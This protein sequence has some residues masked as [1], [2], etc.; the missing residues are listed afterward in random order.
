MKFYVIG[1]KG[2]GL[3]SLAII[4]KNLGHEVKG[5]DVKKYVFTEDILQK[6]NIEI[7]DIESFIVD[8]FDY[9]IIGNTFLDQFK[10]KFPAEKIMTYQQCLK[11]F[12]EKN[13]SLAVCGTHGKTTTTWMLAKLFNS[14]NNKTSYLVGD[15][16]GKAYK[17]ANYFI[18]EAC[19]YC[20][21][22][23]NYYPKSIILTNVDYDHVD[24]FKTK[25][26]YQE[27]FNK[28]LLHAKDYIF[29]N[30]EIEEK[31]LMNATAKILKCGFNPSCDLYVYKY[32]FNQEGIC[33]SFIYDNKDYKNI[34]LPI[35]GEHI[36]KDVL[37][38]ILCSLTYKVSIENILNQLNSFQMPSR[39]FN[40]TIISNK[41]VI[42][43]DYGHHPDEIKSTLS[44]IK[45]KYPNH[46]IV[47]V[48]HPDRYS[49]VLNFFNE[50]LKVFNKVS[51]A[52]IISFINQGKKEQEL[53]KKFNE[54]KIETLNEQIFNKNYYQTIFFFTGSKDMS[55]YIKRLII[56]YSL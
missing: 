24:Y 42:I 29:I 7:E 8:D 49:R 13:N 51:E 45:Q 36:F 14:F 37:L 21:N 27:S 40:E 2:S 50:Y 6:E 5:C 44:A 31:I 17:Q 23:L 26:Q 16:H 43:D 3:S 46:K 48:F 39:R 18:F 10:N 34:K 22:F 38:S 33:F 11:E 1:I 54:N 4:L 55:K 12:V 35:Y 53:I 20:D 47:L 19:E 15:G 30:E 25:E 52:Y 28:F 56:R 41:N 32:K 9:I